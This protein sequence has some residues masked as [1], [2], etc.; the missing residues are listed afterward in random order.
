MSNVERIAQSILRRLIIDFRNKKLSI[1]ALSK[2]YEGLNF[3]ELRSGY[4]PLMEVDF[5][6]AIKDLENKSLVG[7]GPMVPY[8][9]DLYSTVMV[10]GMYSKQE[11]IYLKEKG[12]RAAQDNKIPKR[13]GPASPRVSISGGHFYQSPVGIGAEVNQTSTVNIQNSSEAV[14]YLI[15]LLESEKVPITDETKN[16]AQNLVKLAN[17]GNL[18]DGKPIFQKLFGVLSEG[19]KQL[20]WGVLT[21]IIA[22]QLGVQ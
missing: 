12:Y 2:G 7:T 6:L 3:K 22:H 16:D 10:I 9:N 15:K 19:A 4:G 8:E 14:S 21:S 13:S 5:D 17:D 1:E 18:K 11:Y 20:A